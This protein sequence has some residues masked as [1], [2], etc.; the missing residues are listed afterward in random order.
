MSPQV[1]AE[2]KR[3]LDKEARRILE[4]RTKRE[5]TERKAA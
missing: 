1:R 5:A 4:E 3:I 2:V